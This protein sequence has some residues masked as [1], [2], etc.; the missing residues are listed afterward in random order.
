MFNWPLHLMWIK[1]PSYRAEKVDMTTP[2]YMIEIPNSRAEKVYI[3]FNWPLHLMWLEYQTL[4]EKKWILSS[5]DHSILCDYLK[6]QTLGQ[7][8]TGI[9]RFCNQIQ[10]KSSPKS[11][12]EYIYPNS[13][14]IC[15]FGSVAQSVA[16]LLC[17]R[18]VPGSNPAKGEKDF[19]QS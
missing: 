3:M 18:K 6:Y 14:L 7:S 1:I 4:E 13:Y 10:A 9:L 15:K 2:S 5:N 12:N 8:R 17:N 16:R 19:F 11:H